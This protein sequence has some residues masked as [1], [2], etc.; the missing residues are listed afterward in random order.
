[1]VKWRRP[2]RVRGERSE[3]T[4]ESFERSRQLSDGLSFASGGTLTTDLH[5]LET[6][7]GENNGHIVSLI[8]SWNWARRV[9]STVLY[10]RSL[11]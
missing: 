5:G 4:Q 8:V 1:M 6:V 11:L 2:P 10:R 3:M 7:S 9:C